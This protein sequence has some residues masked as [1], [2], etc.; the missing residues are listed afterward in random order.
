MQPNHPHRTRPLAHLGALVAAI[1]AGLALLWGPTERAEA[2]LDITGNWNMTLTGDLS[3]ACLAPVSQT[4]TSL[5]IDL[6]ACSAGVATGTITK[7]TGAF[8]VLWGSPP[9]SPAIGLN[10]TAT[11]TTMSGAWQAFVPPSTFYVGT[12]TGTIKA[13]VGGV[14]E[15]AEPSVAPARARESSGLPRGVIAAVAAAALASVL[16][17]G[18]TAMRARRG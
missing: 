1:A 11:A 6:T 15:L 4:G 3:V 5:S 13:A 9:S 16:A 10:G 17:L 2:T 18:G 12:F 7:E 8:T 14:A